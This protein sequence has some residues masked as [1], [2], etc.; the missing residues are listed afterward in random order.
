MVNL[1]ECTVSLGGFEGGR[2]YFWSVMNVIDYHY[3][4]CTSGV[5]G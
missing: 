5:V 4:G 3:I 2:V 1:I